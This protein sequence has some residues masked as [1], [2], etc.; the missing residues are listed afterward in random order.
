M[1]HRVASCVLF[2]ATLVCVLGADSVT[3]TSSTPNVNNLP[4]I[5]DGV[6]TYTVDPASTFISLK[7]YLTDTTTFKATP[8]GTTRDKPNPGD[9]NAQSKL[10]AAGT[11]DT[12]A[13]LVVI[14][15]NG[16]PLTVYSIPIKGV[17]VK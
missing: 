4:K 12:D 14:D 2:V 15:P 8:A 3:L 5:C 1:C 11:Y 7:Y 17:V 13:R 6:G 9:W 16:V 10:A